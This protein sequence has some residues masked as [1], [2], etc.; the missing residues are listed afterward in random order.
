MTLQSYLRVLR[1]RWKLIVA[2]LAVAILAAVGITLATPTTYTATAQIFVAP[3]ISSADPSQQYQAEYFVQ[4]QIATYADT[5]DSP[6]VLKQVRRD[7][8]LTLSDAQLAAK[9]TA[10]APAQRSLIDVSATDG[11]A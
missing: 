6:E 8:N 1:E 9:I 3:N 2:T 11:T 4:T 10:T 7:L 5:L